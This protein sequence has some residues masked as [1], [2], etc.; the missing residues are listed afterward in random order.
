MSYNFKKS[1]SYTE[2]VGNHCLLGM[3][4]GGGNEE[5]RIQR[6]TARK[7]DKD[8]E[9]PYMLLLHKSRPAVG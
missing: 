4:G 2:K 7:E 3:G 5:T 1:P 8:K 9:W 6:K